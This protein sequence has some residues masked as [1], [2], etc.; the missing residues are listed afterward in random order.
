ME[1]KERPCSAFDCNNWKTNP[2]IC[3]ECMNTSFTFVLEAEV[4]GED[5][6]FEIKCLNC[7]SINVNCE[8]V[9][10]YEYDESSYISGY[11]IYCKDCGQREEI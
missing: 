5:K 1:Y 4:E 3:Q 6:G 10:D 8:T 7:G 9:L 2:E 11:E